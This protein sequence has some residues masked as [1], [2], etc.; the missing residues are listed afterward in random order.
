MWGSATLIT[1]TSS[2]C[3]TVTVMTVAVIAHRR[4][5]LM[6]ASCSGVAEASA[7]VVVIANP[8]GTNKQRRWRVSDRARR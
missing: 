4:S 5:A 3:I 2:T 8:R 1:V 6:G 7:A